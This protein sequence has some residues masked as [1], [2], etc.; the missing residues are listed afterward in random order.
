MEICFKKILFLNKF[1]I[2]N[3][4]FQNI[5]SLGDIFVIFDQKHQKKKN[6]TKQKKNKTKKKK[7][8]KTLGLWMRA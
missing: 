2:F 3:E 5:G 7:K 4:K 8:K 6:K 1:V